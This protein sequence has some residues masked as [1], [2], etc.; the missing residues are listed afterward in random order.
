M[1]RKTHNNRVLYEYAPTKSVRQLPRNTTRLN[2]T[3]GDDTTDDQSHNQSTTLQSRTEE[4]DNFDRIASIAREAYDA[5]RVIM[6]EL[7]VEQKM[8]QPI[9]GATNTAFTYTNYDWGNTFGIVNLN[10]VA[11]NVNEAGRT[12]DSIKM[13]NLTLDWRL[14]ATAALTGNTVSYVTLVIFY[15]PGNSVVGSAFGT[16]ANSTN[17]VLEFLSGSSAISPWAPKDFDGNAKQRVVIVGRHTLK[18]HTNDPSS[19]H[20]FF[21]KLHK[22]T[23]WENDSAVINTG[24]LGF[25]LVSDTSLQTLT[26]STVCSRLYFVDN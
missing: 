18:V 20:H 4:R 1:Q 9:N 22:K 26:T 13:T 14:Q 15:C 5:T 25:F 2:L 11:Q 3:T 23:Q 6:G 10:G 19:H 21:I 12:G 16:A 17:G 7:N 24:Y 8:Y